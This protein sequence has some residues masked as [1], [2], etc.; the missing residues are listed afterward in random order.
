M[1]KMFL[2]LPLVAVLAGC[3]DNTDHGGK[4]QTGTGTQNKY[5]AG[6]EEVFTRNKKITDNHGQEVT[7]EMPG[8]LVINISMGK[9][10][11][12]MTVDGFVA[13]MT[14]RENLGWPFV[15]ENQRAEVIPVLA[16]NLGD[17]PVAKRVQ[18]I[19]ATDVERAS[20]A[21]EAMAYTTVANGPTI[22]WA[23]NPLLS[24]GIDEETKDRYKGEG[25][26]KPE[27]KRQ[28]KFRELTPNDP[29]FYLLNS[30]AEQERK[31]IEGIKRVRSYL[32]VFEKSGCVTAKMGQ[33]I[34]PALQ[35]T[36]YVEP[37]DARNAG[38][39]IAA[40]AIPDNALEIVRT[41]D[42]VTPPITVARHPDPAFTKGV[43]WTV[44][45]E[46]GKKRYEATTEGLT[47]YMSGK[48]GSPE[49]GGGSFGGVTYKISFSH[50]TT[51]D[52]EKSFG[53]TD[54]KGGTYGTGVDSSTS[55]Q[56]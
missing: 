50:A 9:L 35:K 23:V 5:D 2:L 18:E 56:N 47:V 51:A 1:K 39:L 4:I 21:I 8:N 53:Y 46:A 12:G 38:E 37:P 24:W 6:T 49:L 10:P 3:F 34:G 16:K 19:A 52:L 44:V 41:C 25:W 17:S 33:K 11:V 31:A 43:A 27:C 45:T 26:M 22:A 14:A 42:A 15:D 7:A 40:Q 29:C 36:T 54:R 20:A 55:V 28:E 30:P 13:R 48:A 32:R